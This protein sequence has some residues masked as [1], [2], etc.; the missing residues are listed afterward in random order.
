MKIDRICGHTQDV[1]VD[2]IDIFGK[3]GFTKSCE[4]CAETESLYNDVYYAMAGNIH[5][6]SRLVAAGLVTGLRPT[7][8][9]LDNAGKILY[10]R[11]TPASAE[12]LHQD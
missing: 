3:G 11:L 8:S 7:L 5:S 12:R 9:D 4:D 10:A 2:V 1:D 6:L